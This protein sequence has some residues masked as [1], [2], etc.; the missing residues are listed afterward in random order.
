MAGMRGDQL[1]KGEA[2]R[3]LSWGLQARVV[4]GGAA[5]CRRTRQGDGHVSPDHVI[6]GQSPRV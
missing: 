2:A 3:Q 5:D 6:S 4:A 1:A